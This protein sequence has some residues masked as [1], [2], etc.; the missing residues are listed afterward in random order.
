[1]IP[2][3][4]NSTRFNSLMMSAMMLSGGLGGLFDNESRETIPTR[5]EPR[6]THQ[7]DKINLTKSQRKGKSYEELQELRKKIWEES[8]M[9]PVPTESFD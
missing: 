4:R 6:E 5:P 8:T 9:K 7:W 2:N 3:Q 1:M